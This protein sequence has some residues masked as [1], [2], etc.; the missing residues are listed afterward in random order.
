MPALQLYDKL[1]QFS[2]FQGM[3]RGDLTQ[4]VA[5]T[6]FGFSKYTTGKRIIKEGNACN[7]LYLLINGRLQITSISDDHSY[8]IIEYAE[9][10][11][12]I[13]PER[14]FGLSQR[15]TSDFTASTD[16]NFI[17]IDKNEVRKLCE[18]FNVFQIN[19]LNIFAT[20]SQKMQQRVWRRY[21]QDLKQQIVRFITD[22]CQY[23]AGHKT[24]FIKMEQL[25]NEINDKRINVSNELNKMKDLGLISISRGKI[26]IPML[27]KLI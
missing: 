9:A 5:H 16:V 25:A 4:I 10:P 15:F 13:Q 18:N 23:P 21:P 26:V 24:V 20:Q 14:I 8:S 17:T 6:K 1:L 2:L 11:F 19:C 7:H 22:R 3:S 12:I 27:E